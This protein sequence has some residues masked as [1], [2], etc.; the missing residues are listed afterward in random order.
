M[1]TKE[2]QQAQYAFDDMVNDD[3]DMLKDRVDPDVIDA[4]K[5]S[6]AARSRILVKAALSEDAITFE[7]PLTAPEMCERLTIL[8][9]SK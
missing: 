2:L 1:R 5:D 4:L 6:I 9:R 3:L 7:W 8:S